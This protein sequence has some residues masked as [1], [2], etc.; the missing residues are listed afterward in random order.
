MNKREEWEKELEEVENKMTKKL[1][2]LNF[3][4]IFLFMFLLWHV[5][6]SVAVLN[7]E[8]GILTNGFHVFTPLQVYHIGL[9]GIILSF[10]SVSMLNVTLL[11]KLNELK[12]VKEC[13]YCGRYKNECKCP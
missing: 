5:D 12:E 9:Y 10:I 3:A 2:F 4:L 13:V 8:G 1:F 11:I 6:L 7:I